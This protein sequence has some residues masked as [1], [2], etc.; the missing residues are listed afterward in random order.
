IRD[1]NESIRSIFE[2][3]K[4][5]ISSA[6]SALQKAIQGEEKIKEV[7]DKT[8]M[9]H[10]MINQLNETTDGLYNYSL[11]IGKIVSFINGISEQTNLLAL[12][13]AIEA[14][15][16]GE[17]GKGFAVVADEVK[18][19]ADQSKQSSSEIT[20]IIDEIQKQIENMRI[21]MKKSVEGIAMSTAIADEEGKAFRE[22]I[23][24][25]ETVNEQIHSINKRLDNAKNSMSRINDSSNNIA[26]ITNELA[27]SSTQALAA[28]E[29]QLASNEEINN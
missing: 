19:L 8:E 16:A 5:V 12:N 7:I 21:G 29:E 15:R 22:I 13:A 6:D 3:T 28:L 25:N 1:I 10:T 14:A 2:E 26:A 24:A 9:V 11:K 18:K 23:V 17:A 4:V 27:S 20:I